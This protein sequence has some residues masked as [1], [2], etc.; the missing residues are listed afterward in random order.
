MLIV[1]WRTMQITWLK[2]VNIWQP[3]ALLQAL[4]GALSSQTSSDATLARLTSHC[5]FLFACLRASLLRI[6]STTIVVLLFI[7]C[8][9]GPTALGSGHAVGKAAFILTFRSKSQLLFMLVVYLRAQVLHKTL[10]SR[11]LGFIYSSV[12]C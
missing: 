12:T 6:Q 4:A 5:C 8:P 1:S 11:R 9:G 10:T 7:A 2:C 3:P